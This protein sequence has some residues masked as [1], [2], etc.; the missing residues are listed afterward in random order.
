M[1]PEFQHNFALGLLNGMKEETVPDKLRLDTLR[2][3]VYVRHMRVSLRIA[4]EEAFPVT[5]RLVGASFFAQMAEQFATTHPPADGWLSAYGEGFPEFVAQYAPAASLSYLPDV[6]R[7]EWARVRAAN[8]QEDPGLDLKSLAALDPVELENLRLSLHEA[9]SLI[10]SAF[11]VFD[12]WQAHHQ[13]ADDDQIAQIALANGS[14][15]ILV[16]RSGPLDVSVLLL[17]PGEAAFLTAL[18][19]HASFGSACRAAILADTAYDL[20]RQLGDLVCARALASLA[21]K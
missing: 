10:H 20:S 3:G 4:I 13:H 7:I 12:I 5:R 11:P 1:L 18:T 2:F 14:Q 8:A 16:T 6:A 17:P 21:S 15:D 9:A 19:Q